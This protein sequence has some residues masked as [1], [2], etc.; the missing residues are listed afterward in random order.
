MRCRKN[1]PE[2][3]ELLVKENP[4]FSEDF[5]KQPAIP[6]GG[7]VILSRFHDDNIVLIGDAAHAM[8]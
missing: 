8:V 4:N 7:A 3:Y 6:F 5:V 2:V 1:A